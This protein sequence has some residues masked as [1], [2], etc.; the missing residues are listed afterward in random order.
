MRLSSLILILLSGLFFQACSS[1][2][3]TTAVN[4][5]KKTVAKPAPVTK[6]SSNIPARTINTRDVEA[7]DVVKFAETLIGVKYKYGS[8]VK[9]EGFDCSGFIT[10]VFKHF[11]I[12]VPRSSKDFTNAGTTVELKD[13]KK[14]DLIL[15]TGYDTKGWIVGHMG[16][17]TENKRGEVRFIHAPSTNSK[18][19]M[20]S[21]MND[22]FVKRFVKVIRVFEE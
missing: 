11:N 15:F 9:E 22:Y 16:M 6:A 2:K 20:I 8:A 21:G 10:Y 4:E 14:G 13:S 12:A 7:E 18:G 17:I 5:P 1:S 19:V 3:K